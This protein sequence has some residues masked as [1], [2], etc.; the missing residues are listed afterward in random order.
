MGSGRRGG[1][2]ISRDPGIAIPKLVNAINLL[3]EHRQALALTDTQFIRIVA[4]KRQ[5]DS[6]NVPLMR[7]LDSLQRIFKGGSIMFGNPSAERRD[8]LAEARS[9]VQE[10]EAGVRANL[11]EGRDKAYGLLSSS[12]LLK[13]QGFEDAAEKVLADEAKKAKGR[14]G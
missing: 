1:A 10:S 5:V 2:S 14:G 13:A 6:A 4:L 11:S 9:L 8:S 12:Q 7:R 3:I